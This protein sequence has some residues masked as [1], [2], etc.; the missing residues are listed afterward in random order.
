[1][2]DDEQLTRG[3]RQFVDA[4]ALVLQATKAKLQAELAAFMGPGAWAI[5]AYDYL[6]TFS[7]EGD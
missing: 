7:G 1:M 2:T 5:D 3:E 4:I 6:M